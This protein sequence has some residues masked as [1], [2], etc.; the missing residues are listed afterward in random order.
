VYDEDDLIPISA[1]QH[2]A[3]CERQWGLIHLEG[4]WEENSLTVQGRHLHKR[5]DAPETEVRGDL[6]LARGLRLRSLNLGLTGKADLVEFRR[7]DRS[8]DD[9]AEC[10]STVRLPG[11]AGLWVPIPVEYKRGR[12]KSIECDKVQLCAQAL[13]LEEMLCV[14]V[15]HGELYYGVPKRRYQVMIDEGLRSTT[16]GLLS[17]LRSLTAEGR[18]PAPVYSKKCSSCSLES[19]CLPKKM[20]SGKPT[21]RYITEMIADAGSSEE[22]K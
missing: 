5:V 8:K 11:V 20:G 18:T 19:R 22:E 4:M 3:F 2:L 21:G 14:T 6:R 9:S 7:V 17:R 10:T 15:P 13:C 1:L 12:P 16:M